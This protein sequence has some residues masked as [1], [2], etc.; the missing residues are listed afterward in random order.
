MNIYFYDPYLPDG[1]ELSVGYERVN[2]LEEL[3]K[4]CDTI[5]IHCPLNV[6]TECIIDKK[7]LKSSKKS[8]L[9]NKYSKRWYNKLG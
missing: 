9:F 2:S 4:T 6:E 1:S 7:I 5:S 8:L 3:F